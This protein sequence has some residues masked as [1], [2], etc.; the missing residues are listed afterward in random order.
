[1][2][3]RRHG[4][5]RE[6][7]LSQKNGPWVKSVIAFEDGRARNTQVRKEHHPR[8]PADSN[9]CTPE[10]QHVSSLPTSHPT[11]TH[12]LP[13]PSTHGCHFR[14]R[15]RRRAGFWGHR[16]FVVVVLERLTFTSGN[17]VK[18]WVVL[19]L[20]AAPGDSDGRESPCSEG[21]QGSVSGLGRSLGEGNGNPLQYSCLENPMDR[22]AWRATVNVGYKELDMTERL[23]LPLSLPLKLNLDQLIY[24]PTN[25]LIY[26]HF[27][28]EYR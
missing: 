26:T 7:H 25:Q 9:Q 14:G 24:M 23:T 21:D 1:M 22:G 4:T 20:M 15:S 19:N 18:N 10:E 17:H 11:K 6:H 2:R 16:H 8:D 28:E 27:Q 3:R 12:W 13:Y 5:L